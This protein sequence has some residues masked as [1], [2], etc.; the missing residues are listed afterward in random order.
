MPSQAFISAH[1]IRGR[2]FSIGDVGAK[3]AALVGSIRS[4][5]PGEAKQGKTV[6]LYWLDPQQVLEEVKR[7]RVCQY[8][9]WSIRQGSAK[10]VKQEGKEAFLEIPLWVSSDMGFTSFA[11]LNLES[12]ISAVEFIEERDAERCRYSAHRVRDLPAL[13]FA[14]SFGSDADDDMEVDFQDRL[15]GGHA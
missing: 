1:P 14:T 7:G 6:V 13:V 12:A 8:G 4:F 2:A 10:R 5:W 3:A 15:G 11:G 9:D